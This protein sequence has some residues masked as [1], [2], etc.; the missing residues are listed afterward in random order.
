MIIKYRTSVFTGAGWRD[1]VATAEAERTTPMRA[2]VTRV[3]DIDGNGTSG[4]ASRTGA[5]R[6]SYH[7]GSVA[8]RELGAIKLLS[9]VISIDE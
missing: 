9:C 2:R 5:K 1:V 6:Q 3:L 4:V 8:K 7:V